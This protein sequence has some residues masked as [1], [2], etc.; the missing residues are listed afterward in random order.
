MEFDTDWLTL[1]RH[2]IRLRSTKGFPTEMMR[3]VTEVVRLA[4]DN[5]MSARA[6]LVEV[7]CRQEK[8]YDVLVGTTMAED[9]VC[10]PQ[11]EA[12]VAVVLGLLPDQIHI[13]VTPVTQ[14]EV[15]LHF[16]VYERMLSEKLSTTP[17]IL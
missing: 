5:N 12:A 6:R 7:V 10:A 11:L 14:K 2:R 1:G 16:G 15:D 8:T 9:K 17:P 13:T 4:I 3:T